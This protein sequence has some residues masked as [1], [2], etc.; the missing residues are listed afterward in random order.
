MCA[1]V[2]SFNKQT[3]KDLYKLNSYRGEL[4][5][6]LS[7]F[8]CNSIGTILDKLYQGHNKM[9]EELIDDL[10]L[11]DSS[12]MIGHS[13]AP[14]TQTNNIHPAAYGNSLLWHNGIIKQKELSEDTWD[15]SW[16]L[17]RLIDYG[18]SSLSD[19][20]GTFA[21]MFFHGGELFVFRNEISPLFIDKELNVSSTKFENSE[22]LKPN[23]VFK[24]NL[25]YKIIEPVASFKTKENPYYM[26]ELV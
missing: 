21:C 22:S 8:R 7:S 2:G 16:L 14:T 3:L 15:T 25:G 13:Q 24:L 4:S 17:E 26:P 10:F 5:H 1:I 23:T 19:I 11:T 20:N 9:P 12:Y 6:S 18:W